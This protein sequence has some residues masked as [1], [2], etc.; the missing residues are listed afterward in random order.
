MNKVEVGLRN[1]LSLIC[2]SLQQ[3]LRSSEAA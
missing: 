1:G 2:N 3:S